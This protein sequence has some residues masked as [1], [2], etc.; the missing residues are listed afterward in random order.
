MT[1]EKGLRFP[2]PLPPLLPENIRELR[3]QP[4]GKKRYPRSTGHPRTAVRNSRRAFPRTHPTTAPTG[5][6]TAIP[7]RTHRFGPLA[8]C[9][10]P[11][12][13]EFSVTDFQEP[14][15]DGSSVRIP[16]LP[17]TTFP[18]LFEARVAEGPGSLGVE[19][20]VRAWSYGEL[21]ERANRVAHWLIGRGVGPG[22]LV[23]VA[24]PRSAEQVAVVL[25][26]L[27]AGAAYLP[28][29]LHYPKDRIAYMVGDAGPAVVLTTREAAG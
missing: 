16:T 6:D 14:F 10:C 28:V 9:S 13:L 12:R 4:E 27:K 17:T 5:S 24:M 23:A 29:D 25:G 26:V 7:P 21:N 8:I 1:C 2:G 18:A 20:A 3:S 15:A 19:S 22:R 11:E